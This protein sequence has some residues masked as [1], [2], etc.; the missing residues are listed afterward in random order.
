M[1]RSPAPGCRTCT[2]TCRAAAS[3][4]S[5]SPDS[6]GRRDGTCP[7]V[8]GS[9]CGTSASWS[10][11]RAAAVKWARLSA[12]P[13]GK[14][15][16]GRQL[17][18]F[19]GERFAPVAPAMKASALG[20]SYSGS[21][22][23]GEGHVNFWS[24]HRIRRSWAAERTCVRPIRAATRAPALAGQSISRDPANRVPCPEHFAVLHRT[25]PG[26]LA[27]RAI[28]RG[29]WNSPSHPRLTYSQL[30]I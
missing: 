27:S 1:R 5:R 17:W 20:F 14:R 15:C 22:V 19:C 25:P 24:S 13:R 23:S 18:W 8:P 12:R 10:E 9:G 4:C 16:R 11:S 26:T 3:S 21:P 28:G 6:P 30:G 7:P 29:T 2:R